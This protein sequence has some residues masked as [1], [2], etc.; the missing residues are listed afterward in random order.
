[1]T[2]HILRTPMEE[3]HRSPLHDGE[4][5]FCFHCRKRRV[6]DFV[7]DRPINIAMDWYWPTDEELMDHES[8]YGPS[9]RIECTSCH[10]TDGDCFPGTSREWSDE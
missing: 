5:R 8:Y 4:P 10:T 1:M 7:V 3:V 6:F 9:R 2:L